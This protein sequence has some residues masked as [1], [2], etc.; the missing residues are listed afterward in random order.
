MNFPPKKGLTFA[1]DADFDD[2]LEKGAVALIERV[3]KISEGDEPGPFRKVS[4]DSDSFK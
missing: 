4:M 2:D 3:R 1:D